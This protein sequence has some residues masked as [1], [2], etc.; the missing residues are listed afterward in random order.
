MAAVNKIEIVKGYNKI[1]RWLVFASSILMIGTIF[2]PIFHLNLFGV[3]QKAESGF[4]YLFFSNR[5]LLLDKLTNRDTYAWKTAIRVFLVVIFVFGAA[6]LSSLRSKNDPSNKKSGEDLNDAEADGFFI[7]IQFWICT[8]YMVFAEI[9]CMEFFNDWT[10]DGVHT[11]T[12]IPWL[13]I[14]AAYVASKKIIKHRKQALNGEV[15]PLCSFGNKQSINASQPVQDE[16]ASQS[17]EVTKAELLMTY[18]KLL[19]NGVI[20]E[21]EYN[22]KKKELL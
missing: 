13:F 21:E 18:K 11:L 20:S 2:V 17:K 19:D 3:I 14:L 12:F 7:G 5:G 6:G 10:L 9:I 4:K 15:A 22:E 1:I 8:A 16:T